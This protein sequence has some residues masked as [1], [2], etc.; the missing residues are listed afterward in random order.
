MSHTVEVHTPLEAVLVEQAL[1]MA[2]EL[3]R[4]TDAA[5]DGCVLQRAET[6]AL[7]TGREFTRRA[8]ETALQNQAHDAEKKMRRAAPVPAAD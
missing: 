1:L 6:V 4:A 8:L 3:Q 2:R 7:A 5:P